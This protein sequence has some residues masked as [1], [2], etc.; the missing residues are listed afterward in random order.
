MSPIFGDSATPS[1][2]NLAVGFLRKFHESPASWFIP[3]HTDPD[4]PLGLAFLPAFGLNESIASVVK[5]IM[6]AYLPLILLPFALASVLTAQTCREV[7]RDATGRVIQTINHQKSAGGNV[8]M[9]T[10][11]A[12]GRIIGTA[13][14]RTNASGGSNTS[15]RDAS[16]RMTGTA[17]TQ[18]T[19]GGSSR[20]TYRDA[21]GRVEGSANTQTTGAAATRT[22]FRDASGRVTGSSATHSSSSGSF[23]G[24]QRDASGRII[25]GTSGAGK[26]QNPTIVP[27]PP[28][29]AKK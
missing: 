6:K 26:C 12:S 17:S 9:T 3:T 11:D 18:P 20:T 15:Y 16:G 13:T 7:V 29:G 10:R 28:P 1:D 2:N 27:V 21:S 4:S 22:Q 24:T 23:N 5:T 25:G 19:A 8:Q 14:T